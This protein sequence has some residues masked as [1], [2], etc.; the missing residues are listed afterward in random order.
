MAVA[1]NDA[2]NILLV[3]FIVL[4]CDRAALYSALFAQ[5]CVRFH[6]FSRIL[7]HRI[8]DLITPP[9]HR[10]YTI[11]R[12]FVFLHPIAL[13]MNTDM[14]CAVRFLKLCRRTKLGRH[15]FRDQE[16][17]DQGYSAISTQINLRR[18]FVCQQNVLSLY[19]SGFRLSL[20]CYYVT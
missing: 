2:V 19:Y 7:I 5:F 17:Q 11:P 12:L 3:L 14:Q 15:R 18:G 9:D 13:K 16:S 1:H 10:A 8:I 4:V 20:R 6:S